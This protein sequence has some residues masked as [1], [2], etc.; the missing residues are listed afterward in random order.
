MQSIGIEE[1]LNMTALIVDVRSPSEYNQAHIPGAINIPIFND[2]ERKIIGTNYKQVGKQPAIKIGLKY[3][4]AQML[5]YIE[6]LEACNANTPIIVH[7]WR[8]GMRSAAMAWLFNLYG[9]QVYKLEGGY[10]IFRNWVLKKF[11]DNYNFKI[12]GGGTGSQKTIILNALAQHNCIIDLEALA[13]HKGSAFGGINQPQQDR[14]E[15]FE[16]K[17]ALALYKSKGTI[18][19]EDESQRI[20][21]LFIPN[22]LW[23]TLRSAAI[24]YI[25]KSFDERLVY[26]VAEY[27]SLPKEDL[28]NATKRIEKNLGGLETKNVIEH[29]NNGA[30]KNAFEILLNYYDKYYNK[31]LQKRDNWE[32]LIK[33]I[34]AENISTTAIVK[35]IENE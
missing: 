34:D 14:Q 16:N 29:L 18:Y 35:K 11:E 31:G 5:K 28:L 25:N 33:Y 2:A 1:A 7:C 4:G 13:N 10:K 8:G 26:L 15:F 24:L 20:G 17:L 12:I 27:G 22:T 9:W 6:Q 21:N 3:F 23:K 32:T 30:I 19:V